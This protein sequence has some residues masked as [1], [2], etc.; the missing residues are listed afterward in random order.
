MACDED[1]EIQLQDKMN[2]IFYNTTADLSEVPEG[3]REFLSYVENENADDDFTKLLDKEVKNARLNEEWRS[4]Y[5]KTYVNDMDMKR[6]GYV[7]GEKR[8]RAEGEKVMQKKLLQNLMETQKIT[9]T[10]A[11]KM[12]GI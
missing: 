11:R 10:E 2:W 4:E 6:E 9:E 8:G 3:I 12:L 1:E 7:E 5:L